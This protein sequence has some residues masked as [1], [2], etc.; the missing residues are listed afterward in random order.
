MAISEIRWFN[1][2]R[3]YAE[4]KAVVNP[5]EPGTLSVAFGPIDPKPTGD[6]YIILDTD[7]T[8]FSYVWSCQTVKSSSRGVGHRPILWILDREYSYTS[9]EIYSKVD[10][11]LYIL[12]SFGYSQTSVDQLRE[13]VYED[14][15]QRCDYD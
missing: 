13:I 2:E 10:N 11:A 6:N 9:E 14:N 8:Q 15:Q 4:G 5:D 1:N 12:E 7:N 3:T